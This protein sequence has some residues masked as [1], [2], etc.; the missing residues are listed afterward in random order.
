VRAAPPEPELLLVDFLR[1]AD[2]AKTRTSKYGDRHERLM[3][4]L[5][6]ALHVTAV[7]VGRFRQH[8]RKRETNFVDS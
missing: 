4:K 5:L 7:I 2:H 8:L 1:D 3:T 6:K